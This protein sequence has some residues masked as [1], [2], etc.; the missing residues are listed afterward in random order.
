MEGIHFKTIWWSLV[1]AFFASNMTHKFWCLGLLILLLVLAILH[2]KWVDGFNRKKTILWCIVSLAPAGVLFA[3]YSLYLK[4]CSFDE[5]G[6]FL[7]MYALGELAL[8]PILVANRDKG[9]RVTAVLVGIASVL[10]GLYFSLSSPH[11]YNY[12]QKGYVE[13]FEAMADT[14]EKTYVLKE[15]KDVDFKALKEK[16][17]P[18]VEEA[19]KKHDKNKFCEAVTAFCNELHDGHV[20]VWYNNT[21]LP[22]DYGMGVVKLD[23]GEV[24]AVCTSKEVQ[25]SGIK[26]GTVI[27][28]WGGKPVLEAAEE[29]VEDCGDPVKANEEFL[30]VMRLANVGG[31]IAEVAFINDKG[32]E[33]EVDLYNLIDT[34]DDAKDRHTFAD[35]YS[36]FTQTPSPFDKDAKKAYYKENFSTKMLDSKCGYIRV[37]EEDTGNWAKDIA[38]YMNGD[39]KWAREMF[40]KKLRD[41]KSQG[42]EYLVIDIRNNEGGFDE[43]GFGLVSLL[44][45]DKQFGQNVGM[46][47]G[48]KYKALSDHDIVGD[49]EFADLKVVALTNCDCASAGD[50]LALALSKLPNVTLAGITDPCGIDQETGGKIILANGEVEVYYPTGLVLDEKGEPRIDTKADRVSR[51]PV[52]QRIPL[53]KEAAMKIFCDKEDYE[54]D[55]A[56]SFIEG[57][58]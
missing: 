27:T 28:K 48:G 21:E 4:G 56:V 43:I 44:T 46:R 1:H 35:T 26:D 45:K 23:S 3:H 8:I 2:R 29:L 39:H 52:E 38:G 22:H 53:D 42:M 34:A 10:S 32:V 58:N 47:K 14:M 6:D 12:S 50:G 31:V 9:Y 41:L 15:W 24:I 55:W 36:C 37:I 33:E 40:R 7:P 30:S 16:Y 25:E 49:G 57:K 17:K 20:G 13:S 19:E 51:D 18:V 11:L 54:L 5:L